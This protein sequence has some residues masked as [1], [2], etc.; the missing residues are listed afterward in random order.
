[1]KLAMSGQ[2]HLSSLWAQLLICLHL[3]LH[4]HLGLQQGAADWRRDGDHSRLYVVLLLL[5]SALSEW[6][7][8]ILQVELL[9]SCSILTADTVADPS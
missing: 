2:C 9:T 6:L 7:S 8:N 3:H 5:L 4:L 1:M